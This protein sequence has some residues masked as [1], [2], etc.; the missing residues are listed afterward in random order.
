MAE[1]ERARHLN[2]IARRI[3][4]YA[5]FCQKKPADMLFAGGGETK[6]L[7]TKLFAAIN[8]AAGTGFVNSYR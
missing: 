7:I 2:H 6:T 3:S 1:K 4:V 8:A 5:D